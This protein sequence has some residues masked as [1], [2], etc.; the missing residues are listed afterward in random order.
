MSTRHPFRHWLGFVAICALAALVQSCYFPNIMAS[1]GDVNGTSPNHSFNDLDSRIAG[2]LVTSAEHDIPC[3]RSGLSLVA[4]S[5]GVFTVE[6]CGQRVTYMFN[7]VLCLNASLMATPC[8]LVLIARLAIGTGH[9][10]GAVTAPSSL[11]Q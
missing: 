6:G 9:A 5:D 11:G 1:N 3:S 7:R 10:S 8:K 2:V 4:L